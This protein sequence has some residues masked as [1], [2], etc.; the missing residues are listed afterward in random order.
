M[1]RGIAR[2]DVGGSGGLIDEW[3]LWTVINGDRESVVMVQLD[4]RWM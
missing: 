1:R 4:V 2:W 3:G